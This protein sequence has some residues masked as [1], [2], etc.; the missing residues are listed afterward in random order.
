MGFSFRKS[1]KIGPVRL[2]ASK[3]GVGVSAG[4]KDARI[5]VDSKG[6]VYGS[7]GAK[8][9]Y[10]RTQLSGAKKQT[11]ADG[12]TAA[13]VP[14]MQEAEPEAG[15]FGLGLVLAIIALCIRNAFPAAG[16]LGA[17]VGGLCMIGALAAAIKKRRGNQEEY[18]REM[19]DDGAEYAETLRLHIVQDARLSSNEL[20][21]LIA[22]Y[23]TLKKLSPGEQ[24]AI[25]DALR[26]ER[27]EYLGH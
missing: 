10:Y 11:K 20:T 3:S 26:K 24:M 8:G 15:V 19:A 22:E 6:K 18:A 21:G 1:V 16:I 14:P 4:V 25:T 2:N 27:A 12:N 23:C 5:G 13:D 17:I 7:A 9:V